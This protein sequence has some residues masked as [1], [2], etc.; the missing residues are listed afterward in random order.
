MQQSEFCIKVVY[1]VLQRVGTKCGKVV[2]FLSKDQRFKTQENVESHEC[3]NEGGENT[4]N[5]GF[6]R[7]TLSLKV[8]Q[9]WM[10]KHVELTNV[11]VQVTTASGLILLLFLFTHRLLLLL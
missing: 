11:V 3:F 10:S 1:G 9:N 4:S 2:V 8:H 7:I 5:E 6:V